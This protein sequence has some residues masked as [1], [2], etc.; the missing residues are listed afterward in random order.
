M[1]TMLQ[2]PTVDPTTNVRSDG[3]VCMKALAELSRSLDH[4]ASSEEQAEILRFY[5][6]GVQDEERAWAIYFLSGHKPRKQATA[7]QLKLWAAETSAIPLWLLEESR[8]AI[9]EPA[10]TIA[11]ILPPPKVQSKRPV[12]DWMRFLDELAGL[13]KFE[14][15]GEIIE[16]WQELDV[17]ERVFFNRLLTGAF[18]PTISQ[19][20]VCK[21]LASIGGADPAAIAHRLENDWHPDKIGFDQLIAT[22][23]HIDETARPYPFF[24]SY[25]LVEPVESLGAPSEWQAE[26]IWDGVRAQFIKRKGE[27]LVWSKN[28]DLLTNKLPELEKLTQRIPDGT[29]LDGEIVAHRDNTLLPSSTLHARFDRSTLSKKMIQ[30]VPILFLAFDIVERSGEDVRGHPLKVRRGML[31]KLHS[32][33]ESAGVQLSPLINFDDWEDV[34]R[35]RDRARGRGATGVMLK[36]R[37]STYQSGRNRGDWWKWKADPL[38]VDTVLL[39][40]ERATGRQTDMFSLFTFGVWHDGTLIPCAKTASGLTEEQILEIN[41]LVR[42]HMREKFGPVCRVAPTLVFEIGFVGIECSTRRKSGVILRHPRILRWQKEKTAD[43]AGTLQQLHAL[44]PGLTGR[45]GPLKP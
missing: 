24:L 10:E 4:S 28:D 14:K 19:R 31:E 18:R 39:Y 23:G 29:V 33:F 12:S 35:E 30:K 22:R 42:K 45:N 11:L 43:S 9:G 41:A 2:K 36:H 34:R 5:L 16:A 15:K 13:N 17:V 26:W 27:I 44:V 1:G 21:V 25:P 7:A 37:E 20:V 38:S 40:A 32:S 8:R 3:E 6:T